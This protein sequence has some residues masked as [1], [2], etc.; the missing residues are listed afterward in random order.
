MTYKLPAH[1]KEGV[2][3]LDAPPPLDISTSKITVLI[4]EPAN[5]PS[6]EELTQSRSGFAKSI[7][8]DPAEDVWEND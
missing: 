8:L 1:M 7:L 5:S 4:E 6:P 3:V 2:I